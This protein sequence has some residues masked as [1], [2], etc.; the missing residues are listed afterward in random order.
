[1]IK[2]SLAKKIDRFAKSSLFAFFFIFLKKTISRLTKKIR[3]ENVD[4]LYVIKL[5]GGGSLCILMPY[6]AELKNKKNIRLVLISTQVCTIF[7]DKIQLFDESINLNTPSGLI[8]FL[9]LATANLFQRLLKKN[10]SVAINFEFH[11]AISAYIS[12]LTFAPINCGIVNNFS[13]SFSKI[14]DRTVFYNGYSDIANVYHKL[15]KDSLELDSLLPKNKRSSAISKRIKIIEK[16]INLKDFGISKDYIAVSP[17]SS[18]LAKERELNHRQLIEVITKLN[19]NNI[20]IYLLGSNADQSKARRFIIN[21][22]LNLPNIK[23]VSLCGLLSISESAKVARFA[24]AYLTID[25][26]LNHY[27]R[28]TNAK[29]IHS[30]WGPTDP[31][32]MLDKNFYFGREVIHYKK[33][34]CSPCIHIIDEPPCNGK[35]VCID[36]IFHNEK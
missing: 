36:G 25:S 24:N 14:Y 21:C 18:G 34:Y 6:L 20:T 19:P 3:I 4:T 27:V 11:S 2:Y 32:L 1:M 35:N 22:R 17:F 7:S 33:V 28:M 10:F 26:G 30:F 15:I 31:S 8:R 16:D 13:I 5:L 29:L 12:S 23:I 9:R